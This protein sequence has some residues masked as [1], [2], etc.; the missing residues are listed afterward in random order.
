MLSLTTQK[1]RIFKYM[2]CYTVLLS[3]C[4]IYKF[5]DVNLDSSLKTVKI[6]FLENRARI[7]NPQLAPKLTDKLQLKIPS[8]TKLTRTNNDDAN[9]Q[10][11][12]YISDYS[13]TTAAISSTQATT[14]RLTVSAHISSKN[15]VT[16]KIDE[17]D[18]S[19][20][21][22]FSANLSLQQAE[23]QLLDEIVRSLT[24]DIFNHIFSNW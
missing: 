23:A 7:I 5:N 1:N 11:S 13:V 8:Q 21:F 6:N 14:N 18:V 10:I 12:G 20:N 22:D 3:G 16:G 19:R 24:D 4:G 17:F 2:L 15:N 9:L